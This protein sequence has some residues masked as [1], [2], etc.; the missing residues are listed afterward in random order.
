MK[1]R[2]GYVS[3][4]SSSSFVCLGIDVSENEE[5]QKKFVNKYEYELSKEAR[6]LLP[7]HTE[8]GSFSECGQV[9]GWILGNGSSDDGSFECEAVEMEELVEYSKALEAATGIKPKLM[10]GTYSS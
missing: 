10:G 8:F 1:T 2:I 6:Q 7:K 3:N 9:I 4:S 5:L